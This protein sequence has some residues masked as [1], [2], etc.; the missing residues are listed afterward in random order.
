[1]HREAAT[2]GVRTPL[3]RWIAD[4]LRR[5][6]GEGEFGRDATLPAQNALAGRYR[7]SRPTVS[8]AL[9]LLRADGLVNDPGRGSPSRV[10]HSAPDQDDP[11]PVDCL[12]RAFG[13]EHVTLDVVSVTM[14]S[15]LR[16]LD[17]PFKSVLEGSLNPA[18]IT[19]R[20]LI[21]RRSA[22]QD[23]PRLVRQPE[24]PR[25][26]DRLYG[27]VRSFT[28]ALRA[29]LDQLKEDAGVDVSLQVRSTGQPPGHKFYLLNG[30]EVLFG[31]YTSQREE[32]EFVLGSGEYHTIYDVR[33]VETPL[34]HFHPP[35]YGGNARDALFIDQ[36]RAWFETRWKTIAVPW[37]G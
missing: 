19:V 25:P 7:V 3:Y 4:D 5:R 30:A 18:S 37:N 15:L 10:L 14:Q 26:G 2:G 12:T 35:E 33:G 9:G 20:A 27:F 36:Q 22:L 29:G 8:K 21:P 13:R 16:Y 32:V 28:Q 31:T 1:M 23:L 34:V 6:I 11:S 24:D 17:K